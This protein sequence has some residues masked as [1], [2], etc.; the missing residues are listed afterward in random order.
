M[1]QL[2][3]KPQQKAL[4]TQDLKNLVKDKIAIQYMQT[5]FLA[6]ANAL[7]VKSIIQP[8]QQR[9][10]DFYKF[11]VCDFKDTRHKSEII[12]RPFDLYLA[13]DEDIQIYYKEMEQVYKK[14]NLLPS[15]PGN[16]PLLEAEHIER[17]ANHAAIE[18]IAPK[19][20]IDSKRLL[21]SLKN[22]D[23]FL[24]LLKTIFAPHMNTKNI[25]KLVKK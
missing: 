11:K 25:L 21:Y 24:E 7:T 20:N 14:V 3:Q 10:V 6:S 23:E 18:Y 2:T 9:I 13:S 22:Y 1:E 4:T 5:V 12:T 17:Q 19:L 15:K 16:C 8:E